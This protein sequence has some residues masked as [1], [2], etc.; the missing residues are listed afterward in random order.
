MAEST[1]L[2]GN[3]PVAYCPE[4]AVRRLSLFRDRPAVSV[5]C[6]TSTE[7]L[8]LQDAFAYGVLTNRLKPLGYASKSNMP[9]AYYS[10]GNGRRAIFLPRLEVAGYILF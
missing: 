7:G 4:Q 5:I 8:V 1:W 9:V 10:E 6:S 3:M 2:E